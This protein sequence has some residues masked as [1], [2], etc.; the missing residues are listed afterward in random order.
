MIIMKEL[1]DEGWI[2]LFD[3]SQLNQE[4][5]QAE[6]D[7]LVF[8]TWGNA[9]KYNNSKLKNNEKLLNRVNETD[10]EKVFDKRQERLKGALAR[11][12]NDTSI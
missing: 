9:N 6:V 11:R 5:S 8:V 12:K 4:I 3:E 1:V 7:E 10:F 2:S